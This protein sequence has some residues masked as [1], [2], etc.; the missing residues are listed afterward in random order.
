MVKKNQRIDVSFTQVFD[1]WNTAW[2]FFQAQWWIF[3]HCKYLL[4]LVILYL[5]EINLKALKYELFYLDGD[6]PRRSQLHQLA[7]TKWPWIAKVGHTVPPFFSV[8][9]HIT[10]PTELKLCRMILDTCAH[11]SS[12]PDFFRF[13]LREARILQSSIRI[14]V[15]NFIRL[16]WNL[17]GWY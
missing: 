1:P 3:V 8:F 10:W 4:H 13:P 6:R 15:Y 9:S 12:V 7:P 16:G 17:A 14:A 11:C 5:S 2:K